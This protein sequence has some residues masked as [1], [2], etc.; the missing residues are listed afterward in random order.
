MT[1]GIRQDMWRVEGEGQIGLWL[2]A[3]RDER[4][5]KKRGGR[6]R[7]KEAEWRMVIL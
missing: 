4:T 1:E 5:L 7:E 6:E 3:L 2:N